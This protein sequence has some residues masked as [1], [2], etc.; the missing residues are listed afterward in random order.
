MGLNI[1]VNIVSL[2]GTKGCYIKNQVKAWV[3]DRIITKNREKNTRILQFQQ[4]SWVMVLFE[5]VLYFNSNWFGASYLAYIHSCPFADCFVLCFCLSTLGS[6]R[7]ISCVAFIKL[8][9]RYVCGA[10]CWCGRAE[11]TLGLYRPWAGGPRLYKKAD[12]VSHGELT[13]K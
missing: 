6:K 2:F 5:W 11:P 1:K 13:R 3:L 8:T 9:W 12:W 7:H 4:A 10:F